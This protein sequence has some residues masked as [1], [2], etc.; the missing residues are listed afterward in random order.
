MGG[1]SYPPFTPTLNKEN[2]VHEEGDGFYLRVEWF[3]VF[4]PCSDNRGEG[5]S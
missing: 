1:S 3:S 2:G 4:I 5:F